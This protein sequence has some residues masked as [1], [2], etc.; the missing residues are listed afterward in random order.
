MLSDNQRFGHLEIAL[1]ADGEPVEV[2]RSPEELVFL[3]FDPRI[4]RLVELHILQ[5]GRTLGTA[6]QASAL[7]RAKMAATLRGPA[8]MRVLEAGEEDGLVYYTC[9]LNDGEFLEDYIQRRGALHPPV[10]FSLI[11]TLLDDLIQLK[12]SRRLVAGMRLDRLMLTTQEDTFLQLRLYDYGLSTQEPSTF[13]EVVAQVCSQVFL[14]LTGLLP[15]EAPPDS[16]PVIA[17]QPM[18]LR[19]AMRA[20]LADGK[21]LPETL[22]K[23]RDDIKEAFSAAVPGIQARNPRKH[24]GVIPALQPLSQLQDLLLEKVPLQTLLGSRHRVEEEELPRRLP[25]VIPCISTRN[26]APVTVHLLP[27]SRIVAKGRY[28]AVPLQMGRFHPDKHPNILRSLSV[29]ENPDWTFLTEEREPGFTLSRLMV[30]RLA[31]NPGEVV[32]LLKQVAAGIRQAQDCGVPGMDLHPSNIILRVG[33]P[34]PLLAREHERLMQ[35]RLDAWPPFVVKLRAHLTMRHLYEPLLGEPDLAPAGSPDQPVDAAETCRR[36][37]VFLASYLLTG[38]RN[39]GGA[40]GAT[41]PDTVPEYLATFMR[42]SLERTRVRGATLEPGEFLERFEAAIL[43]PP[44]P[45]LADRLRGGGIPLEEMESVGSVSDFEEDWTEG[46]LEDDDRAPTDAQPLQ[47]YRHGKVVHTIQWLPAWPVWAAA[48]LVLGLVS[49][50]MF[51]PGHAS[52]GAASAPASTAGKEETKST[53]A[54]PATEPAKTAQ[55]STSAPTPP[56]VAPPPTIIES[57]PKERATPVT[58]PS[59]QPPVSRPVSNPPPPRPPSHGPTDRMEKA[60]ATPAAEP[61]APPI[62]VR[63][64]LLPTAEELARVKNLPVIHAPLAPAEAP[65]SILQWTAPVLDLSQPEIPK[66][67]P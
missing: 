4:Q 40:T 64:A 42:E 16:Q 46:S 55:I 65:E 43:G 6:A 39:C 49:W 15:G 44:T 22:E 11:L 7:E 12:D 45:T 30:E 19:V 56:P 20:A 26:E 57:A 63:R 31:L 32:V 41:F 62:T 34:G 59:V 53:P 50:W 3:A 58:P 14:M 25:F 47:P 35:R 66:R 61:P 37:F 1:R 52:A 60:T 36:A 21:Q 5:K 10:A 33:R 54:E 8:F 17:S 9:H 24:L 67:R 29:W 28:E 27:P 18:R 48:A 2:T 13:E 51:S 38:E 23:L